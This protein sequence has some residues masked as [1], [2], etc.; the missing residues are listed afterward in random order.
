MK[1][2]AVFALVFLVLASASCEVMNVTY[3]SH[4]GLDGFKQRN[5]CQV[6][7]IVATWCPDCVNSKATQEQLRQTALK[8]GWS[9]LNGDVGTSAQFRDP[10]NYLVADPL[11]QVHAIPSLYM[12][13]NNVITY[14]VVD[15]QVYDQNMVKTLISKVS[16]GMPQGCQAP[17]PALKKLA[18]Q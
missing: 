11:Y 2:I 7:I 13:V 1:G 8:A 9:V 5:P 10:K 6:A 3:S 12:I 18:L 15:Q 17:T 16:Q 4:A 14:S